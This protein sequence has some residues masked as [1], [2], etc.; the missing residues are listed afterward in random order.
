MSYYLLLN[1]RNVRHHPD[2]FEYMSHYLSQTQKIDEDMRSGLNICRIAFYSNYN[3]IEVFSN[4][5]EYMSYYLLLK[6]TQ[7]LRV[8]HSGL[9]ICRITFCSNYRQID[10]F[11]NA[12]EY[13]SYYLLLKLRV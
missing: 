11:A 12:F 13:M 5:F 1:W 8:C 7:T 6:L 9:N 2:P 3:V 10:D 4:E